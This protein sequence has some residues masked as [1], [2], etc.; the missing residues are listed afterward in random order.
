ME[1]DPQSD[2]IPNNMGKNG[3]APPQT[4]TKIEHPYVQEQDQTEINN[5]SQ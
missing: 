4:Q 3:P 2:H 1:L 5:P